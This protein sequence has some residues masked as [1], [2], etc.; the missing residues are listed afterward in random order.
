MKKIIS[1]LLSVMLMSTTVFASTAEEIAELYEKSMLLRSASAELVMETEL[2]KPLDILDTI[3]QEDISDEADIDLKMIVESL[4]EA[5]TTM[6][7][8]TYISEDYKKMQLAMSMEYDIPIQMNSEFALA[9]WTKLGMWMDLDVTDENNPVVKIIYKI[10]FMKKYMVM[11]VSENYKANPEMLSV[12][13][14]DKIK[15]INDKAV[16]ILTQNAEIS[17][18]GNEY[19]LKFT[20]ET[21]KQYIYDILNLSAE[22][23]PEETVLDEEFTEMISVVK[24]F[25]DNITVFGQNGL[26]MKFTKN[27]SGYITAQDTQAHICLN[28]YDILTYFSENTNGLKREDAFI[29]MTFKTAATVT[30]H[31]KVMPQLPQLTDE[32]CQ[33]VPLG[34]VDRTYGYYTAPSA[35]ILKNNM[36]YYPVE[37]M[38]LQYAIET[39]F[40]GTELTL[41]DGDNVFTVSNDEFEIPEIIM[42]NA[43]VYC[44]ENVLERFNMYIYSTYYDFDENCINFS[45]VYEKPLVEEKEEISEDE[46]EEDIYVSPTLYYDFYLDR[47]P[48]EKNG[49]MYMPVYEFV[50]ELFDGEF[51]FGPGTLIYT[52]NSENVF[53]IKTI[54]ARKGD[55]YLVVNEQ[56][57]PLD[58]AVEEKDGVLY[59]PVSFAKSIGLDTTVNASYREGEGNHSSYRFKMPNPEYVSSESDSYD[60]RSTMKKLFYIVSSDRVPHMENG[61]V[62]I[63]AFDFINE[64]IEGEYTFK[65]GGFDYKASETNVLGIEN[66]SVNAG[67]K[68][69][70]VNGEKREISNEVINIDNVLRLPIS[71]ISDFGMDLKGIKINYGITSYYIEMDN[72]LYIAEEETDG[73]WLSNLFGF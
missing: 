50:K 40:D 12:F 5:K 45:Y 2:N 6:K 67:D 41:K 70:T 73:N 37:E 59:I 55:S 42:E 47:L 54:T 33:S 43:G 20:D 22:I 58:K 64:I 44:T 60:Y 31:N 34:Y 57:K 56:Q 30:D 38:A 28:V 16:E 69:I 25:C 9:A 49:V 17:K 62:Y 36:V 15:E 19:T 46:P 72:P 61:T 51:L 32:N 4:T 48:Y 39:A 71:V 3:P 10:P 27:S 8:D 23:M 18:R 7:Y 66:I 11:D 35:P 13:D 1:L 26:T 65:E 52:A 21:A 68:F 24:E 29:D 63:P 53:G 14:K